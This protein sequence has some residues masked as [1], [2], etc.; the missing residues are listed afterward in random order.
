VMDDGDI[1]QAYHT[2]QGACYTTQTL[3]T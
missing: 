2:A 3:A 1:R